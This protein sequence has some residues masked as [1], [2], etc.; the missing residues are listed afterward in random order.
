M[1]IWLDVTILEA[2]LSVDHDAC[3]G[4]SGI[5]DAVYRGEHYVLGER[6]TL[7]SLSHNP[8]LSQQTRRTVCTVLANLPILGGITEYVS[9]QVKVTYGN[10][11]TFNRI[12]SSSWEIPLKYLAI[13]G[14]KKTVLLAE[15]L[16][17]ARPFE[18]AA[19]QYQVSVGLPGQVAL[20]KSGGG[21]STTPSVLENFAKV[22]QRWSLCITDSDRVHPEANM[23]TT[24]QKCKDIVTANTIVA[25]HIDLSARE[26]ENIFPMTFLAEVIPPT[27]QDKWDWHINKLDHLR[28]DA[29]SYC[30]IKKGTTLRK[31]RSYPEGSPNRVYW[32]SVVKDLKSANALVGDCFAKEE[33][34]NDDEVVCQC[35]VGHGFGEKL[36]EL[37]VGK[38]DHRTVHQSEKMIRRDRNRKEWMDIG[39]VVFEWC[40]AP[41]KTRL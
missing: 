24:A 22:E 41:Q 19:K 18:H 23:D 17:D 29:H 28:P 10:T 3:C 20:E 1:L 11:A 27:H 13:N 30:D 36:L 5:F 40:C 34:E 7:T 2:D 37:V 26:I 38:L 9:L 4:V 31:I 15:N 6:A 25:T 33:C 8:N 12:N 14:V 35:Y 21:G 16:D 39:R 32:E